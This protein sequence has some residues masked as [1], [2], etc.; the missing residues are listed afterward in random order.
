MSPTPASAFRLRKPLMIG[1]QASR[2]QTSAVANEIY[3]NCATKMTTAAFSWRYCLS[4]A[5]DFVV[6]GCVPGKKFALIIVMS[7]GVHRSGNYIARVT[8]RVLPQK[9]GWGA[10]LERA[11][12][13]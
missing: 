13:L 3:F 2:K 1:S 5:D 8:R 12:H 6:T 7:S 11:F 10:E 9:A 4:G